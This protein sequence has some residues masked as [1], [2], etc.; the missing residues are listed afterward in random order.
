MS[1]ATHT[2]GRFLWHELIT[3]DPKATVGFY[4]ELLGWTATQVDMGPI[5]EYTL[6]K[7]NGTDVAGAIAPP[8]GKDIPPAWLGYCSTLD[9][10]AAAKKAAALGGT[11]MMEPADIPN[12][13]RF[14]VFVDGQGAAIAAFK[15]ASER[16]ESDRPELYT[17]CWD[18]LLTSSP[19]SAL[20]LYEGV[21]GYTHEDKDMGPM[22]IY[23]VLK[24]GDRQAAG[25]MKHPMPETPSHWL[26]YVAVDDV[27]ART[28][29]ATQLKGALLVEPR[30]IPGIGRFS[31]VKDPKGA[32]FA[33]FKGAADAKM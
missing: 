1:N 15:A 29:R 3:P 33:L 11:V 16:A 21:F 7:S 30:D 24:R 19:A 6:F 10:D 12:I 4:G 28:K 32:A 14:A 17:F 23:H 22:G 5:G 25:I 31:V 27:D 18:E 20:K 9:V 13:G 2:S 8:P 26:H